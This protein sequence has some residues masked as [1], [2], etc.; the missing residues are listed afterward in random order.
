MML[1]RTKVQLA[2]MRSTVQARLHLCHLIVCL[3]FPHPSC[4]MY[5]CPI[6]CVTEYGLDVLIVITKLVL[7]PLCVMLLSVMFVMIVVSRSSAVGLPTTN[8]CC[9]IYL[10]CAICL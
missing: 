2:C 10:S 9:L 4:R 1:C 7:R 6:E 3:L 5:Q 8:R